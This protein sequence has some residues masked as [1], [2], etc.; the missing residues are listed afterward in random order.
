MGCNFNRIVLN[1]LKFESIINKLNLEDLKDLND[2]H[3]N[4]SKKHLTCNLGKKN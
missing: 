2:V 1:K 4:D 3:L